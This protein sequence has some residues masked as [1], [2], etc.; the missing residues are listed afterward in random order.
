MFCVH[1]KYYVQRPLMLSFT[2]CFSQHIESIVHKHHEVPEAWGRVC[3]LSVD[4][5][6]TPS[7]A[8]LCPPLHQPGHAHVLPLLGPHHVVMV[9][10]VFTLQQLGEY[11]PPGAWSE[12]P[13]VQ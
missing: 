7:P 4:C 3:P 9:E 8:P 1:N 12:E 6:V 10:S 13:D 5:V 2:I 11:E